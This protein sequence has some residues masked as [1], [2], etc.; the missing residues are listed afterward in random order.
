MKMKVLAAAAAVAA[1]GSTSASAATLA[2]L[3]AG[4][5]ANGWISGSYIYNFNDGPIA[6]Q[7]GAFHAND[8]V[9][10]S[11]QLN[12]AVL[13]LATTATE[14]FGGAVTVLGGEDAVNIVNPSY[15]E[16][17]AGD[18]IS[19]TQAYASYA[20]GNL[21]L[22]GGRYYSL[23][24]YEVLGDPLNST[25]SR[26]LLY[27]NAQ[28]YFH[29]GLRAA[30]KAGDSATLF[31]GVNNSAA[32]GAATDGNKKKSLEIGG[33]FALSES[34]S[35]GIYDYFG[36][37]A[38]AGP[39]PTFNYLDLVMTFAASDTL[40]FALNA[41]YLTIEDTLDTYGVAGYVTVG[42]TDKLSATLRLETLKTDYDVG[43]DL[44]VN[45]A[46]LALTYA[47]AANFK[48]LLEGRIDDADED[49]YVDGS[50]LTGTQPTIGAKGI[51]TFGL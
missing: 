29:T 51:F 44:T 22:I 18:K 50:D 34:F 21:T 14:G 25:L 7:Q 42:L 33:L 46:T 39:D 12:Q 48:L 11:F 23:A 32:L 47:P 10:E 19:L 27:P 3:A 16:G 26:S 35:V 13:N 30:Y 28:P 49:I 6:S 45:E 37:E 40:S 41:D 4:V 38:A 9:T 5:S 15:G 31:L 20:S 8:I 43:T 17:G 2:E 1:M 36:D 24:G